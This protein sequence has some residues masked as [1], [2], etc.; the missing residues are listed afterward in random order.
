MIVLLCVKAV[1]AW[2]SQVS[3][4]S[5]NVDFNKFQGALQLLPHTHSHRCFY[6]SILPPHQCCVKKTLKAFQY[7]RFPP[8]HRCSLICITLHSNSQWYTHTH[9]YTHILISAP[10]PAQGPRPGLPPCLGDDSGRWRLFR[11][12]RD[13]DLLVGALKGRVDHKNE[14]GVTLITLLASS[15]SHFAF[16]VGEKKKWNKE[17]M[18]HIV[19]K[20][21]GSNFD[22]KAKEKMKLNW[23]EQTVG[24]TC[25]LLTA[26][27]M[28][29]LALMSLCEMH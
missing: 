15:S 7:E 26:R 27:I 23:C 17:Q 12:T 28:A 24:S 8:K 16:S 2:W 10:A 22:S 5:A 4:D 13:P 6:I 9:T 1:L 21:N 29:E 18:T 19:C 14:V 25:T 20:E 11:S 3:S